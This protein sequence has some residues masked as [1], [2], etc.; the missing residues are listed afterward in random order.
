[1]LALPEFFIP[2]A[3]CGTYFTMAINS[4]HERLKEIEHA[5]RSNSGKQPY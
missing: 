1:M 2:F 3:F 5:V 4:V